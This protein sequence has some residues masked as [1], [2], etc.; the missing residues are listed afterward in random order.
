MI[1]TNSKNYKAA[2]K[3]IGD[4][5]KE[6]KTWEEIKYFLNDN[7]EDLIKSLNQLNAF[8]FFDNMSINEWYEILEYEKDIEENG[9][10]VVVVTPPAVI[11]PKAGNREVVLSDNPGSAWVSYKHKLIKKGFSKEAINSIQSSSHQ[12]LCKLSDYT[13]ESGP[14]KGL[15]IGNVQSGKTANM[16]ALISMAAD[17][18]FNMFIVLSG[19]IENLRK[20]T[21]DRL[22]DD[23]SDTTNL[24]WIPIDNVSTSAS[25][26]YSMQRLLLKE[27]HRNRYLMVCLKNAARLK[28]ILNWMKKDLKNRE[29]LKILII[30]DEADQ[31]GVNAARLKEG[32]SISDENIERTKINRLISN[33]FVNQDGDNKKV[34]TSVKA[35]NYVAYT[36]TPYANV[37]NEPSN[38]RSLYPS[39]FVAC[40]EVSKSYFGPQHIFGIEGEDV[41][42]LNIINE[43]SNE[44]IEKINN[45]Y[46]FGIGKIPLELKKAIIWFYCTLAIRRFYNSK[47][48]VSMLIHTSQKQ[49]HHDS[50]AIWIKDWLKNLDKLKFLDLCYEVFSEQ[51]KKLSKDDFYK[52][53]PD[54]DDKDILDYP[55]FNQ[56]SDILIDIFDVGINSI[57]IDEEG[58]V[59]YSKG[60][61]LCV[62]NCSHN[63]I[64]NGNEHIR[65]IYPDAKKD[66]NFSLG[67]IVIGGATLSRGLTIEGLTSTYFL[68]TVKQADTLMQ[69]GRWFGYRKGYELLP[70]IWM[71]KNTIHKFE[72][73]SL[74]D[75]ELR[76][77]M[78]DMEKYG[79]SPETVGIRL[80][81]HPNK[82]FLDL[83]SRNKQKAA[84]VLEI[85]FSGIS[86][87]TTMF[88]ESENVLN[89]NFVTTS[90]FIN[91]L[92][93]IKDISGHKY[94]SNSYMWENIDSKMI[95]DYFS[96]M[97]FPNNDTTFLNLELFTKCYDKLEENQSLSQWDVIVAG[98]DKPEEKDFVQMGKYKI[99]KVNRSRKIAQQGDG[100]IRIGALRAMRDLYTEI[101]YNDENLSV[102][103]RQMIDMRNSKNYNSIRN[104]VGLSKTPLLVIYVIDKDSKPRENAPYRKS[105]D[106]VNDVVGLH[107]V[108]PKD[109]QKVLNDMYVGIDPKYFKEA[110]VEGIDEDGN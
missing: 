27:E 100:F 35:L 60:I 34:D 55:E 23:L 4:R 16:A 104:K 29:N 93:E 48:P 69:M 67:F 89:E 102:E 108:I 66:I 25:Y 14:V 64:E 15:V 43:I 62:D 58:E 41:D 94:S 10:D 86:T 88:F 105:M 85:D 8:G 56:I 24:S 61:N 97:K 21:Q 83:T 78:K 9:D 75:Y 98:I 1:D 82:S 36:A 5:R 2:A 33:F 22:I 3:Y 7:E 17:D 46:K 18:G 87:Q 77:V 30:D 52:S 101:N 39:N 71:S 28:N 12:I 92:G 42:G 106:T 84:T 31:A 44:E 96:K 26:V 90:N 11:I 103:D 57:K 91:S 65:L 19:T 54:Y 107:I 59:K 49:I 99:C 20:Q 45:K 73:L 40:L 95:I 74:L 72:F 79:V 47:K 81:R 13:K 110:T 53:Y 6:L 38:I 63:Y 68:R 70:R 51:T 80:R 50:T 37:L 109:E 32:E 76:N